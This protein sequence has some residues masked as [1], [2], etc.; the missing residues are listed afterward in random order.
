MKSLFKSRL[1]LTALGVL[2]LCALLWFVADLVAFS[3]R[4]PF[5]SVWAR[6]ALLA[7]VL[8]VWGALELLRIW[9]ARRA[10][11]KLIEGMAQ[12]DAKPDDLQVRSAEELTQLRA[13]FEQAAATLKKARF[14][15]K[16]GAAQF[17]YQMPWYVFIGAPGSGKT[18]ALLRSGL[19]F[20]LADKESGGAIGGVGGTRNCDWWFTDEA[21]LLDTAGRFSTQDSDEKVD[22]AAWQ[23][24][25]DLLKRYRPRQPLNGAILTVSVADLLQG[26]PD[27]RERYAMAMKRRIQ[28]LYE[29]LGVRFPVYLM[30]TKCDLLAGFAE[31]FADASSD[32]RSQVWGTTFPLRVGG[33]EGIDFVSL[34][35]EEFVH[36]EKRLNARVVA[37]LQQER[38]PARRATLYN[39]PQ[40]FSVLRPLVEEFIGQVFSASRFDQQPLLRGVYFTS[41]TQEGSPVDRV[42]GAFSRAMGIESKVAAPAAT[43]GKSYFINRMLRE[44]MFPEAGIAGADEKR[45]K[46]NRFITWASYAAIVITIVAAILAWSFSFVGNRNLIAETDARVRAAQ[47]KIDKLPKAARDDLPAVLP[48]LNDLRDLPYGYAERQRVGP[49]SMGFG[50]FQGERLRS[51]ANTLYLRVLRD[52]LLP[53]LAMRLEDQIREPENSE[54][55]YEALKAYLMLYQ[56]KHLDPKQFED[57]MLIDWEHHLPRDVYARLHDDLVGHLRAA[58]AQR[59][60]DMAKH[61]MDAGL[62]EAARKQLASAPLAD[63]VW[64][65]IRLLGMSAGLTPFRVTDAAGPAA[66]QVLVRVKGG[67]LTDELPGL[68]TYD[69]YNKWF[70]GEADKIVGQMEKEAGWVLG[71]K[72]G[73]ALAAVSGRSLGDA[74]R[75]LYFTEYM[76]QWDA[77]LADIDLKPM[78][79]FS[80]LVQA[81]SI[82][83]GPDSP[84]KKLAA[85]AAAQT[86]LVR[87]DD[88]AKAAANKANDTVVDS[89]KKVLGRIFGDSNQPNLPLAKKN[90]EQVVDDR[91]RELHRVAN[92]PGAAQA[93]PMEQLFV[94]LQQLYLE[95]S[96]LEREV[97]SGASTAGVPASAIQVKAEAEQQPAPL[98]QVLRSLA[99]A[100]FKVGNDVSRK[101]V[102]ADVGGGSAFCKQAISGR[103]PFASASTSAEVAPDDFGKVFAPG[104]DLDETFQ[105][106]IAAFV[107]TS[108]R[109]W[110]PRGE[111]GAAAVSA[112]TIAQF[113]NASVIRDTFF[114]GGGRTPAVSADLLLLSS[115]AGTVSVDYDGQSNKLA[116]GQA[117]RLSWPA[118]KPAPQVRLYASAPTAAIGA[119]GNW[120][121]FRLIDKGAREGGGADRLRLAY[122]LDGKRVVFELRASSVYNPFNL[123]Q[124]KHFQ[125][126][127]GRN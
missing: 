68:F 119:D 105:K 8:L 76:R 54:V 69:G 57:W 53:R 43:T 86:T 62:V 89:T 25:L 11:N 84:L 104:G 20:P 9:L 106:S 80:D 36:L 116:P 118:Q 90:P 81:A 107:D 114:R 38:D 55:Q 18:T 40:Q 124:L 112:A 60:L 28:E 17:L 34:A 100:C 24:F 103:Y 51:Q 109:N 49:W 59:P 50:L 82:L 15:D 61:R 101:K 45:E 123:A 14:K 66:L 5:E 93:A 19:R 56:D 87:N 52:T 46:R 92:A 47:E 37:R 27:E 26:G 94:R 73:G 48:V 6:L 77:L 99:A 78:E 42:L 35:A 64:G 10:N 23:G 96:N 115:D 85:A 95:L 30:V 1:F 75:S 108:G 91:F 31:F 41:G 3:G 72:E 121:L 113:Q 29:R 13:R 33:S 120:A 16:G 126:P 7:C 111:A 74:V 39:F 125:C 22:R 4:H 127:A 58:L 65:R 63:R 97:R 83:S 88:L 117:V 2:I 110:K 32:D 12:D 102:S 79:Q 44:V 67:A 122:Q 98:A 21:V 70:R 71:E